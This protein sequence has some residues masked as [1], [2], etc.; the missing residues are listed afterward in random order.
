MDI[1]EFCR[2]F[3]DNMTKASPELSTEEVR[4]K[5]KFYVQTV[6]ESPAKPN[7][8][9]DLIER[10]PRKDI[11]N[12]QPMKRFSPEEAAERRRKSDAV[13][14][15]I[16][17]NGTEEK[18]IQ[19]K[20]AGYE[21]NTVVPRTLQ[22]LFRTETPGMTDEQ[23]AEV[24]DY[25]AEIVKLF[26]KEPQNK[27]RNTK[28]LYEELRR[29]NPELTDEQA[30]GIIRE[31]RKKV[32]MD[33][34]LEVEDIPSEIDALTDEN[35]S[36]EQLAKNYFILER[37]VHVAADA[38]EFAEFA[39]E[40]YD[41]TP[42]E[43]ERFNELRERSSVITDGLQKMR[44]IGNPAYEYLDTEIIDDYAIDSVV[45]SGEA[46]DDNEVARYEEL[47]E[48]EDNDNKR[49]HDPEHFDDYAK[50]VYGND[51]VDVFLADAAFRQS[52]KNTAK[53]EKELLAYGFNM[54]DLKIELEAKRDECGY[55]FKALSTEDAATYFKSGKTF[56]AEQYG[57]RVPFQY[58]DGHIVV[59]QSPEKLF[60]DGFDS[61]NRSITKELKEL[62]PWYHSSSKVFKNMKNAFEEA[63]RYGNITK[64][65]DYRN[66]YTYYRKLLDASNTYLATKPANGG[67]KWTQRHMK[68]GR[69]LKAFA[70]GRLE[71]LQRI[72]QMNAAK[73]SE[74]TPAQIA[75]LLK[76][77]KQ[78]KEKQMLDQARKE[79]R[80]ARMDNPLQWL[81]N[82]ME[83]FYAKVKLPANL[84][85]CADYIKTTLN[86]LNGSDEKFS[87]DN[88][89]ATEAYAQTVGTMVL[90]ELVMKEQGILKSDKTGPIAEAVGKMSAAEIINFGRN[91]TASL[92]GKDMIKGVVQNRN[93]ITF[94]KHLKGAEL[95][96]FINSFDAHDIAEKVS[97]DIYKSQ[98]ITV[99]G[100]MAQA[101]YV[102]SVKPMRG[103]EPD[104]YENALAD[105]ADKEIVKPINECILNGEKSA[106][107]NADSAHDI[108]RA[109]V[110]HSIIQ[111][112]RS[113]TGAQG[114]GKAESILIDNHDGAADIKKK[115][116]NSKA[117]NDMLGKFA[118]ANGSVSRENFEKLLN[119]KEPQKVALDMVK[120]L[121]VE[122][123]AKNEAKQNAPKKVEAIK[124]EAPKKAAG[125]APQA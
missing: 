37:A 113:K 21:I 8:I 112:E 101:Q 31:R 87:A 11:E 105:F 43:K 46:Y 24:A 91:I 36:P 5:I 3:Y 38:N 50:I 53:L 48:K 99:A 123:Q 47:A 114:I 124:A 66:S 68:A 54:K 63:K 28:L 108:L 51:V 12:P 71:M 7:D 64:P 117:F 16:I 56:V 45:N 32:V 106:A 34:L 125:K 96:N 85:G 10:Y 77:D 1:F 79:D 107:V 111:I 52:L 26:D 20:T 88:I 62:D 97:F 42:E 118:G 122:Q 15:G 35:L 80:N 103:K 55:K 13:L 76:T 102:D 22:R 60:T 27:A 81:A 116:N 69:M 29:D 90:S 44:M 78:L 39:P 67:N 119:N 93:K 18:Q 58:K 110:I 121:A 59:A 120:T 95:E 2:F 70:E 30:D 109:C 86:S 72:E 65:G 14:D 25:N 115:I 49:A 41:L 83:N 89:V 19:S 98:N 33:S 57:R 82:R 40:L 6:F 73:I 61:A 84:N 23:K 75:K 17:F 9:I 94:N 92:T 104:Q 74:K 100:Q 4:Q